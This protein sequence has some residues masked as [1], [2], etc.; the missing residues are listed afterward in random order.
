MS[1]SISTTVSAEIE[2]LAV[3]GLPLSRPP[4]SL[5]TNRSAPVRN[6]LLINPPLD[7]QEQLSMTI[8]HLLEV[9]PIDDGYSHP[10]EEIIEKALKKHKTLAPTWIQAIYLKNFNRPAVA[11]GIL[12]CIGRL[13]NDLV[14]P[15]GRSMAMRGLSHP[16][17]EV[18]EAAIR[19]LEMWGGQES[20]EALKNHIDSEPVAWLKNYVNQVINDLTK[21]N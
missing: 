17:A 15:W 9:E 3:E 7:Q 18:R 19:A 14:E 5:K 8:L 6:D 4:N 16:A 11:A 1:E 12:R 10:A 21:Q 20:T 13:K 2:T